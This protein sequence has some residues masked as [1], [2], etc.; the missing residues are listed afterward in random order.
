MRKEERDRIKMVKSQIK[1]SIFDQK[2]S[3]EED[4]ENGIN[5]QKYIYLNSIDEEKAMNDA[6]IRIIVRPSGKYNSTEAYKTKV[7][8][9]IRNKSYWQDFNAKFYGFSTLEVIYIRLALHFKAI[10]KEFLKS[11]QVKQKA[12]VDLSKSSDIWIKENKEMFRD[13]K[14]NE[15]LDKP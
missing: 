5:T 12:I 11:E 1:R 13:S 15:I 9:S 4:R 3:I 7:I 8:I 10:R 2:W 14:L 6:T